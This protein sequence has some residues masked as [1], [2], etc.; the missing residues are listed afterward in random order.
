[1]REQETCIYSRVAF[2]LLTQ[3]IMPERKAL[4]RLITAI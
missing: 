2:I 4:T 1:M 3:I